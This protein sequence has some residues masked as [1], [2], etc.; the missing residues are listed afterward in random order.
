MSRN[1]SAGIYIRGARAPAAGLSAS[2]NY[3][4]ASQKDE[5]P[6]ELEF[7]SI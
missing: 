3:E 1:K 4:Q 7:C 6:L 5:R 2:G